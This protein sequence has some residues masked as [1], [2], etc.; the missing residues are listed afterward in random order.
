MIA[1]AV[2]GLL[3]AM[4]L[5]FATWLASLPLRDASV[6]D[7]VWPLLVLLPAGVA[8]WLLAPHWGPDARASWM[9]LLLAAWA[10][11]LGFHI[12]RRNWGHGEDRRYAAMRAEHGAAFAWRSLFTVFLLQAA[13][14]WIVSWPVL[15]AATSTRALTPWDVAGGALALFGIGFEALADA[16]LARFRANPA[17]RNRVLQDGLWRWSRHPNYFGEACIWWGFGVMAL[18]GGGIASAWSLASPLLMTVLLLRVSGVR[19]LERDITERRPGYVEYVRR[20][21]TFFP[22]PPRRLP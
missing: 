15:A 20:T 4:A 10:L 11:R 7:R 5:G 12:V 13:L 22:R 16:Q 19:L 3:A 9:V 18:A 2:A 1:A 17:S 8:A 21:S 14:A 6:A